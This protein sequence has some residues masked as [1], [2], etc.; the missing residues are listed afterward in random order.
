M[1]DARLASIDRPRQERNGVLVKKP[2]D[3]AFVQQLVTRVTEWMQVSGEWVGA[4][5]RVGL[6]CAC[7]CSCCKACTPRLLPILLL[8]TLPSR[9]C[10]QDGEEATL[11]LPSVN[12][13]QR[14]L[15]YQELRRPQFGAAEPPGF[16]VE[17]RARVLHCVP[18]GV[19]FHVGQCCISSVQRV[20]FT[21]AHPCPSQP[22]HPSRCPPPLTPTPAPFLASC[23]RCLASLAGPRCA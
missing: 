11:E 1:R 3:V 23:R 6:A 21:S 19:A 8:L 5:R 10:L 20:V 18:A 9:W 4:G 12:A 15:T 13:Y 22:H 16:F 2:E 14:L 7:A 17:V